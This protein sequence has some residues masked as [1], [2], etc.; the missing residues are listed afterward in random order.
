MFL[1]NCAPNTFL[2]T[3]KILDSPKESKEEVKKRGM[4]LGEAI[5]Q[6]DVEQKKKKVAVETGDLYKPWVLPYVIAD[7]ADE[8]KQKNLVVVV[9]LPLG[10][11]KNNTT[12][13]DISIG[14]SRTILTVTM[15]WP[16]NMVDVLILL[17]Q[18]PPSWHNQENNIRRRLALEKA[19]HNLRTKET[20][21]VRSKIDI[22]LPFEVQSKFSYEFMYDIEND[23]RGLMVYLKEPDRKFEGGMVHKMVHI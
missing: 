2:L 6:F 13:T 3:G 4:A 10:V 12:N 9:N 1:L 14:D 11:V 17:N 23:F 16:R 15:F 22:T 7:W 19:F 21:L 18:F 5:M 20:D 8:N